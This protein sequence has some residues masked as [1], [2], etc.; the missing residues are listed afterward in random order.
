VRWNIGSSSSK[1]GPARRG[2]AVALVLGLFSLG[3]SDSFSYDDKIAVSKG[4]TASGEGHSV[5]MRGQAL[6]LAGR[7]IQVGSP[8]ADVQLAGANLAPVKLTAS[9]GKVRIISV[10][11]SLDTKT[12]EQQTHYL[13]EKNKGLDTSIE[14]ITVSVDT[15]F[16]QSRF[17]REANI[18]NVTFLSDYRDVQFGKDH[19]LLVEQTHLL[20]RAVMVVDAQNVI[21]YL[22][23]TPELTEMPDMEAAFEFAR[24]LA[25]S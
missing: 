7:E 14:L 6:Q 12:C 25:K 18:K 5:T 20:A 13:S 15:P 8:L 19:G 22:Q 2:A 9:Q 4:T 1:L 24:S 23:V 17:A 21:Q 3:C 11:P 10:V 16:A